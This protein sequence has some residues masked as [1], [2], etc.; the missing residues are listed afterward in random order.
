MVEM[1]F[2][3]SAHKLNSFEK[4]IKELKDMFKMK[5]RHIVH[6]IHKDDWSELEVGLV[7]SL[8]THFTYWDEKFSSIQT[9]AKDAFDQMQKEQKATDTGF[10]DYLDKVERLVP[11]D[12]KTVLN[13]RNVEKMLVNLHELKDARYIRRKTNTIT[14]KKLE[15]NLRNRKQEFTHKALKIRKEHEK[16]RDSLYTTVLDAF[17]KLMVKRRREF[18]RLWVKYVKVTRTI[19]N[20]QHK[21]NYRLKDLERKNLGQKK[22][23][24]PRFTKKTKLKNKN[25]MNRNVSL[26]SNLGDLNVDYILRNNEK[27]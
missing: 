14:N 5:S 25:I 26:L 6:Q 20:L 18:Q 19:E 2:S 4:K 23:K 8:E 24:N 1:I 15:I 27:Q 22:L 9:Y 16:E 12:N 21:E 13:Y 10:D 3:Q 7:K 17:E 11:R